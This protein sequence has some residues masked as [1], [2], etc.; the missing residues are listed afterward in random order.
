MGRLAALGAAV[1][2]AFVAVFV[3]VLSGAGPAG[4]ASGLGE[5]GPSATALMDICGAGL[6]DCPLLETYRAAARTCAGLDWAVLAAVGKVE[7]DHGRSPALGVHSGANAAGAMG[8]MQFL[9]AT[10]DAFKTPAPGHLIP[11]VYD[12]AD[13]IYTAARYL[14]HLG[15]GT[16]DVGRLRIAIVGYSPSQAYV[17]QVLA[18]SASYRGAG[19]VVA[20]V[21]P[22]DPLDGC[23]HPPVT[24]PYGPTDFAGE[25][26]LR[27]FAHFHTGIDLACPAATPVRDVGG[28]GVAHVQFGSTGFGNNVVVEVRTADATYFVR[29]AHLASV[30]V[31]DGAAVGLGDLLG[32]EGSTG[33]STGPH[34]HFETDLGSPAI[35]SAV[36]PSGWLVR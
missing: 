22:G 34:L 7:S 20:G 28:P 6:R 29:Y 26:A 13:A 32:W 1:L 30:A 16:S 4:A 23:P 25:P 24:Q 21:Q 31:A 19:D 14:C 33:F 27:G 12:I 10:W 8:P 35:T 15:A 17:D 3:V 18:V 9:R 2:A 5:R 36:D 11:D